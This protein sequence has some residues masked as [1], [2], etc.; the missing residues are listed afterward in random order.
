VGFFDAF[1][2]PEVHEAPLVERV[3]TLAADLELVQERNA[4]LE[5]ALEDRG[6]MSLTAEANELFTREGIS[7]AGD[8]AEAATA[9][10]P[11]LRRALALRTGYVWGDGVQITARSTGAE[12]GGQD[13]NSVVQ[14]FLDDPGNK[15][16]LSGQAAQ[17]SLER[18][19][20][21]RGDVFMALFTNPRTGRVKARRLPAA[22]ITEIFTD[23]EDSGAPWYYSRQWTEITLNPTTG[24]RDSVTKQAYYPDVTYRPASKPS[25]VG[26]VEVVW[27]APVVHVST[28]GEY[29][30]GF[31]LPDAYPALAWARAYSEFLGDWA[32]LTKSLSRFA[33]RTTTPGGAKTTKAAATLQSAAGLVSPATGAAPVGAAAVGDIGLEAIP[34]SG[35][36]INS[37]S[38]RPLAAMVASG[39]DVPVTMLLADPGVT[40]ARAT[41][42]TLDDPTELVMSQRRGLWEDFLTQILDH[43]IDWAARAPQ[44]ELIKGQITR[45]GDTEAVALAG[46]DGD[47]D[48]TLD[49]DWPAWAS[50]PVE[51]LVKAIVEADGAAKLPPATIARLL[52]QALG[53]DDVDEILAELVDAQGRWIGPQGLNPG[54]AAMDAFDN[55]QQMPPTIDPAPAEVDPGAE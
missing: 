40:G 22:Q 7:R 38:G 31:G 53:V 37:D 11:I 29:Q 49:I 10:N 14:A 23:P 43:V 18:A 8:V 17:Q 50:T 16:S 51:T 24:G 52:L 47:T 28:S 41:A 1:R 54:L 33:W 9:I 21:V 46:D 48:R 42:E 5:L 6:W 34:K 27:D 2:T 15:R 19:L 26:D 13:V 55:G 12:D 35:A 44:G 36:T 39:T 3:D 32:K 45:D 4:D 25:S 20:F 30:G